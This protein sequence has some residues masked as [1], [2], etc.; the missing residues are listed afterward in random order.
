M[1]RG[2]GEEGGE[3]ERGEEER[4]GGGED[5][6]R[7]RGE[8]GGER[9]GGKRGGRERGVVKAL[10]SQCCPSKSPLVFLLPR[11]PSVS[12]L[13]HSVAHNNMTPRSSWHSYWMVFMK[14]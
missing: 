6:K 3:G 14:I 9:G 12:L 5:R 10:L 13:Q 2:R 11:I 4:G 7:R 1:I 8:G